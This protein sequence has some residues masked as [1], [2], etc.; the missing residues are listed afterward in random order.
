MTLRVYAH[1]LSDQATS[2]AATFAA[3]MG[4]TEGPTSDPR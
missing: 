2:A 1:V 3:L 4:P